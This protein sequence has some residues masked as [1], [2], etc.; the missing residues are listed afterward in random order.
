[1]RYN[2]FKKIISVA[3]GLIF[4]A[5]VVFAGTYSNPSGTAPAGN[6]DTPVN[7]S[8]VSQV[9][10]GGLTVQAFLASGS[11]WLKGQTY[12]QQIVGLN[13][14][15][16]LYFG[17]I[18]DGR[19]GIT[20]TGDITGFKLRAQGNLKNNSK[21]HVCADPNGTL[22]LCDPAPVAN[23]DVCLNIEG[24]Q[25]TV[26]D[27]FTRTD[28][29]GNCLGPEVAVYPNDYCVN[30]FGHQ[31][32]GDTLPPGM[33]HGEISG[34]DVCGYNY[35]YGTQVTMGATKTNRF[36]TNGGYVKVFSTL[37]RHWVEQY[38]AQVSV[39]FTTPLPRAI[40]FKIGYCV[41][42]PQYGL[43]CFN[44]PATPGFEP[45]QRTEESM[46]DSTNN[47]NGA[48][49]GFGYYGMGHANNRAGS[50]YQNG[51]FLIT[52]PEGSLGTM[53]NFGTLPT[54]PAHNSNCSVD[55]SGWL[56]AL[57]GN[58]TNQLFCRPGT[59]FHVPYWDGQPAPRVTKIYIYGYGATDPD[60]Y[61]AALKTHGSI[62]IILKP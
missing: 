26:V 13:P 41:E 31:N 23:N 17:D 6:T 33:F 57:F 8:T 47:N 18:G 30:I 14:N 16:N 46:D 25:T 54:T 44:V 42:G 19:V 50:W 52:M 62:P 53:L 9:K 12:V 3:F 49:Y 60:G 48:G 1:M 20:A 7:V 37:S 35:S 55:G 39:G 28:G 27:P 4:V 29:N 2:N 24:V 61:L 15:K 45:T 51:N 34:Q 36:F 59:Y 43:V 32:E 40:S 10:Q 5:G 38:T 21:R 56:A 11:A 22:V 58:A